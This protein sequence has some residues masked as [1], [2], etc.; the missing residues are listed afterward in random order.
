[1]VKGRILVPT[2]FSE[3]S[4]IAFKQSVFFSKK[5]EMEIFLMHI[6]PK[7][8]IEE[9]NMDKSIEEV[10]GRFES[11]ISE[12]S[13]FAE[14][15]IYSRIECG[16]IIPNI[17][18][19]EREINPNFM[20][21][22]TDT[23][24]TEAS[25]IALKLIN[26]VNCPINVFT[27]RFN[28]IGCENIVLPLDLTKETKQKVELTVYLAKI[29]NATVHIVS[30]VNSLEEE[31]NIKLEKQ[32][33]EVKTIFDKSGINCITKLIKTKNDVELMANAINDYAD[34]IESDLIV[35]MTRQ[36]N[37][38]QKFFIGS[39]ATKLIRKANAPI[40]CVNPKY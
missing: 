17:L 26:K 27:G 9:L 1:M 18:E 29:Y 24:E 12:A 10:Q 36:E 4:N 40:L 30:V 3:Q 19:A 28:R 25:S 2:D 13:E 34:S 14:T 21:V 35:I 39:M 8:S 22:G 7:K 32:I 31:E 37:K 20:F 16:K 15:K 5:A 23:S 33:K 11:L 6:I 38:I